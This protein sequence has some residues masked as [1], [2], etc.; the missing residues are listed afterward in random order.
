MTH[1]ITPDFTKANC[2]ILATTGS[3]GTITVP[4][5]LP[6][7]LGLNPARIGSLWLL[8]VAENSVYVNQGATADNTCVLHPV[9]RDDTPKHFLPGTVLHFVSG[10]DGDGVVSLIP[11]YPVE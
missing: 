7:N 2:R 10:P 3:D 11:A 6:L 5:P 9:G 4:T 1:L 8:S